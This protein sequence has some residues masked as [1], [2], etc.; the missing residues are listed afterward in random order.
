MKQEHRGTTEFYHKAANSTLSL[1]DIFSDVFKKH[2]KHDGETLFMAGTS[3]S[4]PSPE[5]MLYEWRKPWLFLRIL[6]AGFILLF[7]LYIMIMQGFGAYAI[8][9]FAFFGAAVVPFAVLLFY[10]EMNIP[11]NIPI[12]QVLVMFFAGGV[13]SLILTGIFNGYLGEMPAFLAP[14]TEEPAKL[15][16]LCLF[17]RN[18]KYRYTLNGILI[19]G[20]IGA[21]FA[22]IETAGYFWNSSF[23]LSTLVIRA[24]LS[25]GGHVIWAAI[26]GGALAMIKGGNKFT[27]SYFK[28][29]VF[30]KYFFI[31]FGLHFMW[32]YDFSILPLPFFG[33]VKYLLLMIAA[34]LVLLS[35]LKKGI[36]QI[37]D[38][39]DSMVFAPE[40]RSEGE[41]G[42]PVQAELY[43]VSGLYA[44]QSIPLMKG[45][46]VL[47]RDPSSCNL[48][49]P[50]DQ[51]GIS[52]THCTV[53]YD[54]KTVWICDNGSSNGTFLSN[55]ERLQ[56]GRMIRILPGQRFYLANGNT[57][58]ELRN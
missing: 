47:G 38:I 31:S 46:I 49:F 28:H 36:R 27:I 13:I 58:F 37:L 24:V 10:W 57:M 25:P 45:K 52:R 21:G 42:A 29:P 54:G 55:G 6:V 4:T 19:G 53:T 43:A 5:R 30:L 41:D 50:S 18:R 56:A 51:E 39:G 1:K 14:L 3:I 16:A 17:L 11:R 34:W 26:Y 33:D 12:Y 20:A 7:L 15:L 48:I 40:G 22:V 44:G 35:L 9:P 2:D 32:N 23:L 8:S